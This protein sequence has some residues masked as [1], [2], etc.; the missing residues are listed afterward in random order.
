[1]FTDTQ[2]AELRLYLGWAGRWFQV[3]T[4]LEQAMS[5]CTAE[6]QTL[7]EAEVV[8]LKAIDGKIT[9]AANRFQAAKVGSIQL[10]GAM[11]LELLRSQGRQSV[12]RIAAMLGVEV[13]HD[14]YS[15]SSGSNDNWLM[16]G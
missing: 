10:P 4:K 14:V 13:R 16:H 8:K 5:A 15:G 6:T 1:M 11:E 7:I 12:G 2:K 3:D 9:D